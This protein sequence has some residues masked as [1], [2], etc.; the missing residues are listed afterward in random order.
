MKI[1][2]PFYVFFMVLTWPI[3]QLLYLFIQS[4]RVQTWIIAK[5]E[6]NGAPAETVANLTASFDTLNEK[7]GVKR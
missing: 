2:N 5:M 3:A 7:R 1:P 6:A 4:V